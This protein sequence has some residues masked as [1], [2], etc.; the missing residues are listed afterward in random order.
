MNVWY[1]SGLF[2]EDTKKNP[3]QLIK[4][5]DANGNNVLHLACVFERSNLKLES[6]DMFGTK[7]VQTVHRYHSKK[8]YR[9]Y[10][11]YSKKD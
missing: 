5:T 10:R 6:E 2:D 3:F 9:R 8:H 1:S 4:Y 11:D 7:L